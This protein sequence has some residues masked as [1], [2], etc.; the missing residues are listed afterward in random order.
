MLAASTVTV[1]VVPLPECWVSVKPIVQ[2]PPLPV[3]GVLGAGVGVVVAAGAGG[4]TG[5]T[6]KAFAVVVE[7]VTL[8][9]PAGMHAVAVNVPV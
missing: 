1:T 4:C 6:L 8:A 7:A 5:V 2:V 3:G 9:T